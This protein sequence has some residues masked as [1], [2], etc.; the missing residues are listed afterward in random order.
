MGL[1]ESMIGGVLGAEMTSMVSK[2]IADQGGV[3]GLVAKFQQGGLGHI[4]Q[5]WVGTGSNLP[6]SAQ[7]LQA[8]LG[9]QHIAQLAQHFG[10][11]A[12]ELSQQLAKVLPQAVDHLTPGG[13]IP[14]A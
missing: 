10:L 9:D 14:K 11:D 8:I 6:I 2:V 5:S 3:A 1:I 7:Q 13:A 4:V 12:H